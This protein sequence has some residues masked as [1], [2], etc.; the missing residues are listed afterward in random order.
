MKKVFKLIIY[1]ALISVLL[2]NNVYAIN[3]DDNKQYIIDTLNSKAYEV[4]VD[5]KIV[6]Q[7]KNYL[8][9]DEVSINA[10]QARYFVKKYAIAR[11]AEIS[12]KTEKE[13]RCLG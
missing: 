12:A 4:N 8:M 10:S 7:I 11:K 2:T 1:I 9:N 6:N 5:G 13:K 3:Y